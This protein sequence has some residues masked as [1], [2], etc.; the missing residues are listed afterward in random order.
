MFSLDPSR[1]AKSAMEARTQHV[2]HRRRSHLRD[3]GPNGELLRRRTRRLEAGIV[4]IVEHLQRRQHLRGE[5]A[6]VVDIACSSASVRGGRAGEP[7]KAS[8]RR[9][10][11][12]AVAA[13][14]SNP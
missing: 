6:D 4:V 11:Q 14:I 7:T 2:T 9:R 3:Q 13:L 12:L 8:P 1:P 10:C 5:Q